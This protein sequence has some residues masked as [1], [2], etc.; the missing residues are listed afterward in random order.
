MSQVIVALSGGVDSAVAALLLKR[1]GWQVRAMF[2]KNWEQDDTPT[3][4]AAAADLKAAQQ[5]A[6]KIDIELLTVNFATEYWDY[7]FTYFLDQYRAG[8]TP[9]PDILCN[10][11]IKFKAFLDH[12]ISLGASTIATG[13]YAK[14]HH[15]ATDAHLMLAQDS[16]KDQT[17]FLYR[18]N[19]HQLQHSNFPL[20]NLT[21]SEVR[22]I[23]NNAGLPNANRPDST[24]LCFI[25]ERPFRQFLA[26]YLPAQPGPIKCHTT[27]QILGQH[28]GLIHYTIGQRRGLGIGGMQGY[29]HTPWFVVT[30]DLP[31]NTLYVVPG[32]DHPLL[33]TTTLTADT[34][35]WI[36]SAQPQPTITYQARIRHRQPLQN[37]MLDPLGHNT[38]R[39]RF[40]H[41]QWAKAP[42]Q[43]VVLYQNNQCLGGCTIRS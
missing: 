38:Y 16:L 39:I 37:C 8:Y 12:A 29:Q 6:D 2:M 41:P 43:S 35:S 33:W 22:H 17:Y 34:C 20:A 18:L 36:N 31:T 40:Q 42:G 27:E 9:N 24:G 25:G 7:V 32:H 21:K 28:Q 11:E 19:Q 30:K 15:D 1:S 10:S 4:C 3:Y 14:I 23:A 5:V 13:H 26:Q